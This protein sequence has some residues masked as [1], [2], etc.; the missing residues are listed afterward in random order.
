MA[1]N[2]FPQAG[3]FDLD[4]TETY[5]LVRR[6][7]QE[8]RSINRMPDHLH[9]GATT[10]LVQDLPLLQPMQRFRSTYQVAF[11]ER[12]RSSFQ[13]RNGVMDLAASLRK[14][15][16]SLSGQAEDSGAVN[17]D[18]RTQVE[19]QS[20]MAGWQLPINP[21]MEGLNPKWVLSMEHLSTISTVRNKVY[22]LSRGVGRIYFS[23]TPEVRILILIAEVFQP[24]RRW[25]VCP[26]GIRDMRAYLCLRIER[27]SSLT[28]SL[29]SILNAS[30]AHRLL[31][32][33]AQAQALAELGLKLREGKLQA[34][35][36][37]SVFDAV[38][39]SL[40]SDSTLASFTWDTSIVYLKRR[41]SHHNSAADTTNLLLRQCHVTACGSP[42]SRLCAELGGATLK[43]CSGF[44]GHAKVYCFY[45]VVVVG[46]GPFALLYPLAQYIRQVD[47]WQC[48]YTLNALNLYIPD[49]AAQSLAFAL[50]RLRRRAAQSVVLT[51][52]RWRW[53]DSW[54]MRKWNCFGHVLR[55]HASHPARLSFFRCQGEQQQ[56]APWS[57]SLRWVKVMV[58]RLVGESSLPTDEALAVRAD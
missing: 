5:L 4:F 14:C 19:V 57:S 25:S 38:V 26:Y 52:S 27:S 32:E 50:L 7:M 16:R 55:M 47:V 40:S 54:L 51:D 46:V 48:T 24:V 15:R 37:P 9:I 53:A 10:S 56:G 35:T 22:V 11:S 41:L 31:P 34:M 13:P 18:A 6:M 12:S 42:F 28:S 45:L 20:S 29:T 43:H 49:A 44:A 36:S 17:T 2:D 21:G 1:T 3:S 8:D 30:D 58:Q 39:G 23:P 33:V